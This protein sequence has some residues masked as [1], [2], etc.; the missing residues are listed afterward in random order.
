MKGKPVDGKAQNLARLHDLGLVAVIRGPS[1]DLTLKLVDALVRGGVT[2]IEITFTTPNALQVTQAL[3]EQY[4]DTILLG[5]GTLTEP[6]QA[7]QALHAGA[8][9]LVSPHTERE[10]ARS[11]TAT[12]LLTMIGALTPSEVMMAKRLGSD[13]IK[14]FPGSLTGPAYV[15]ALKGPF[16]D[17][18]IMPTGG[19]SIENV[20][21]W[22]SAGVFAVGAGSE[23]CPTQLVTEGRFDEIVT[24]AQRFVS[25]VQDA[26][27]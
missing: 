9:F 27:A 21:E 19:V 5:M 26:R 14:L 15:K 17:L 8:T 22:F 10:L 4:G 23:L 2:G 12:G 1:L 25:A 18:R 24:R 6:V 16:P 20:A 13:V 11:M 7:D 3:Q